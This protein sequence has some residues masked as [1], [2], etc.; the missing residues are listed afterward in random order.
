MRTMGLIS[1]GSA[2]TFSTTSATVAG[3]SVA[4]SW[5][6][7]AST[8]G[9][10]WP[11]RGELVQVVVWSTLTFLVGVVVFLA[12]ETEGEG[13]RLADIVGR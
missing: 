1:L 4:L 10:H 8:W 13:W 3:E 9:C 11:V 12:A 2:L 6:M 5:W 7:S